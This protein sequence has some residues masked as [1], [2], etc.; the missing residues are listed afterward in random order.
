MAKSKNL[1][2]SFRKRFFFASLPASCCFDNAMFANLML[3]HFFSKAVFFQTW[4]FEIKFDNTA[5][6][7]KFR[8]IESLHTTTTHNKN[9]DH[10]NLWTVVEEQ[11]RENISR[12]SKWKA[13]LIWFIYS[14]TSCLYE[15]RTLKVGDNSL[16]LNCEDGNEHNKYVVPT[17]KWGRTG[18]YVPN[19]L[20]KIFSFF[21]SLL[22]CTIKCKVTGKH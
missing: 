15:V 18:G 21:L 19:N 6:R 12:Y 10:S 14:R 16:Y 1:T 5:W 17:M 13:I 11:Q 8:E 22:K 2:F 20:N 3:E 9:N 7:L 4:T